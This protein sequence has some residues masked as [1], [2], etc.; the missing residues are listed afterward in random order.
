MHISTS[1][2]KSFGGCVR[3]NLEKEKAEVLFTE[4]VRMDRA[5]HM[6]EDFNLVRKTNPDLGMAVWHTSISFAPEDTEK[7]N[8]ELLEAIARDYAKKFELEQYAVIRHRDAAH[9]HIHIIANRV[10]YD[11]HTIKDTYCGSRGKELAGRLEKKYELHHQIG[12]RLELTHQEKLYGKDKVK[13]QIYEAV[14]KELPSCKTLEDLKT[15]LERHGIKTEIKTQGLSFSKGLERFKGSAVDKAFG[16]KTLEKT[17]EN[18]VK[19]TLE[20]AVP[21]LKEINL[22]KGIIEKGIDRDRGRGMEM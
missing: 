12:K 16:K 15:K 19:K 5:E 17:I 2:G 6:T 13:Y 10:G 21:G 11:G 4:G 8:E 18:I 20:Q 3:Y 14:K 7:V 22:V 9:Q 1:I